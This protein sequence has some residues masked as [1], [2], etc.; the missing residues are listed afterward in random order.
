MA[1]HDRHTLSQ[2]LLGY[3]ESEVGAET[4]RFFLLLRFSL[5]A[6]LRLFSKEAIDW[7]MACRQAS[8][9]AGRTDN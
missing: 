2:R 5:T 7:L 8:R 6:A 4:M 3:D 1:T 9:S